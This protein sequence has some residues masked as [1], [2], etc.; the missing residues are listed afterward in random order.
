[1]KYN[2]IWP[3][4]VC[5]QICKSQSIVWCG[6]GGGEL[7]YGKKGIRSPESQVVINKG[8]LVNEWHWKKTFNQ[9]NKSKQSFDISLYIDIKT[10]LLNL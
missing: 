1:M 4:V 5:R 7:D 6:F 9:V 10:L 8:Y 2:K 3:I